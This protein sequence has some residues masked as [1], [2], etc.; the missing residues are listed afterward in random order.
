MAIS[1]LE[2]NNI[3]YKHIYFAYSCDYNKYIEILWLNYFMSRRVK[4]LCVLRFQTRETKQKESNI[5][6]LPLFNK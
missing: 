6:K 2:M 5:D 1:L 3:Q 4:D